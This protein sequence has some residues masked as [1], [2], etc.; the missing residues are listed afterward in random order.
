[1]FRMCFIAWIRKRLRP[2]P[3][4]NPFPTGR[5]ACSVL[6]CGVAL[7]SLLFALLSLAPAHDAHAVVR[8][9]I[10]PDGGTIYTDRPCDQFN[11]KEQT[12]APAPG[13][14]TIIDAEYVVIRRE[15]R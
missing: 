13:N 5:R 12:A 7:A 8:R 3:L 4:P 2:D 10:G 9:C 11:A 15:Q 6:R 14:E 1:M